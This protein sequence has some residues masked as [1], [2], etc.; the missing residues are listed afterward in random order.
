MDVRPLFT[1]RFT[2]AWR[3]LLALLMGVVAW[4]AFMPGSPFGNFS[5][6]DKLQHVLAFLTLSAVA[7]LAWA[8]RAWHEA[9]V[10]LGLLLYG[11]LI[12]LVQTQLPTRTASAADV[13]A[14]VAGIA[15]GL[16]LARQMLRWAGNPQRPT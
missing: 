11:V 10:A 6:L 5:N 1:A 9:R 2:R 15:L 14:D 16:L 13:V 12:E 4:F 3:L 8:P 7:S